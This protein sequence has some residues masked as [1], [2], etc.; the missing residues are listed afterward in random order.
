MSAGVLTPDTGRIGNRMWCYY[1]RVEKMQPDPAPE[2]G[3]EACRCGI[4]ELMGLIGKGEMEN[5]LNVAAL[6]LV[7]ARGYL[8]FEPI[9]AC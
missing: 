6:F 9:G 7:V 8:R 2:E 3:I 1:A 4:G 5:A